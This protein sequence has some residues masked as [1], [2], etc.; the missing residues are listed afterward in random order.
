MAEAPWWGGFYEHLIRGVKSSLKKCVG[1]ANLT[2]DELHTVVTEVEAVME[3]RP[4]TYLYP[5][6]IEEP[7][8]PS[9]LLCGKRLINLPSI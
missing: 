3:S 4:L 7:L 8:T 1:R 5:D 9:H 2:Y 6:D